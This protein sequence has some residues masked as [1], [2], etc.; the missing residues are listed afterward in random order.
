MSTNDSAAPEDLSGVRP[1]VV[2]VSG[3][4]GD[5]EIALAG[6]AASGGTNIGD[7]DCESPSPPERPSTRESIILSIQGAASW[8]VPTAF[9]QPAT[10]PDDPGLC[11]FILQD[12]VETDMTI[13]N[14]MTNSAKA[15]QV[16]MRYPGHCLKETRHYILPLLASL[17]GTLAFSFSARAQAASL[18]VAFQGTLQDARW[19]TELSPIM[20]SFT[21][22][23]EWG[24]LYPIGLFGSIA[25]VIGTLWAWSAVKVSF[26]WVLLPSYCIHVMLTVYIVVTQRMEMPYTLWMRA[27]YFITILVGCYTYIH[28]RSAVRNPLFG[29]V[30]FL[31]WLAA[32]IHSFLIT[33][34]AKRILAGSDAEKAIFISIVNPLSFEVVITLS[35]FVARS[36]RHN[37]PSSSFLCTVIPVCLK[38]CTGR[39][40]MATLQNPTM[41]LCLSIVSGLT[42]F[43]FRITMRLRDRFLYRCIF[44]PCLQGDQS[45]SA[46]LRNQRNKRLRACNSMFETMQE[47]CGIWNGVALVLCLDMSSD[48]KSSPTVQGALLTGAIQ[49]SVE[50][51]TDY[52]SIVALAV[53]LNVDVLSRASGRYWYWSV[54]CAI[55]GLLSSL[56]TCSFLLYV[57]CRSPHVDGSTW[58]V[59]PG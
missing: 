51:L 41:V 23:V 19:S 22:W 29:W 57:L 46:Q 1:D 28:V 13:A 24:G 6:E 18:D 3:P 53:L 15:I 52:V 9:T 55:Y 49:T 10:E 17:L 34:F 20:A 33:S 16:T 26:H 11:G 43:T 44:G 58:M 59:C 45:S 2:G 47:Y 4:P 32:C 37:H 21:F 5:I 35:R 25:S 7:C 31:V 40:F 27:I 50:F 38:A 54:P 56:S 36:L 48:G 14:T 12:H 8:F 39:F 30:M 42:E